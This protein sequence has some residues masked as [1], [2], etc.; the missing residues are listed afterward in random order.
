MASP[1]AES[2]TIDGF[3]PLPVRRPGSVTELCQLVREARAAGQAIYPLGGGTR[4]DL[5]LPPARAGVA[6]DLR[7]L[8][9]VIDYPARD[10]TITV[11]AGITV[12]RLQ[13]I[14][15]GENQRLP[16]DVAL[17]ERATLGGA[18]ATNASGPRRFGHGTLRDYVIGITVV[19]DRGEEAKAGGRVVKNVAGYDLCKLYTGALGTLGVI[20]Q[21]T[22]K[23]KPLPEAQAILVVPCPYEQ[24]D[25]VLDRLHRT[26][27]R[28]V[29]LDLINPAAGAELNRRLGGDAFF[30]KTW[31]LV[32]GLEENREATDWQVRQL[33]G[34]LPHE[35]GN[36]ARRL[37]D[38]DA[39]PLWRELRDFALWPEARFS[40]KVNMLPSQ[41]RSFT[42]VGDYAVGPLLQVH[43]GSGIVVGHVGGDDFG[44]AQAK[45]LLEALNVVISG[46]PGRV[47][48]TRCPPEWKSALPVWGAPRGDWELMR[49]VKEKLDPDRL[50][51][52]GRFVGGI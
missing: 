35:L 41:V 13:E 44:I 25:A 17:P 33:T 39:E 43:A 34:E 23:V 29:C 26:A 10:M 8:D 22:L 37:L 24:I 42:E 50:F 52:P 1:P 19:N 7:G 5:G 3:G 20:S 48:V 51:N 9:Q 11:Q 27:T 32:I 2:C 36:T 14:L 38:D 12:A 46:G 28:P 45:Q 30:P 6:V 15:R 40:F 18:I 16:V 4:L 49:K 47:T 21:V 31:S